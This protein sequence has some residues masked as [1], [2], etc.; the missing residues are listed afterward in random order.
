MRSAS[1]KGRFL[2]GLW[3][4][5][6]FFLLPWCTVTDVQVYRMFK[7][8]AWGFLENFDF[9]ITFFYNGILW[10]T[11]ILWVC[12]YYNYIVFAHFG[13]FCN[14]DVHNYNYYSDIIIRTSVTVPQHSCSRSVFPKF[15]RG[16]KA[17]HLTR[18]KNRHQSS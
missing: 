4:F 7:Y 15:C 2:L 12:S 17:S 13:K 5:L 14:L 11:A 10:K 18:L 8:S 6:L 9:D 1:L 16:S 3:L